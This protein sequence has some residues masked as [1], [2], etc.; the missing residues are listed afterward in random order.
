MNRF[1]HQELADMRQL[2]KATTNLGKFTIT[3]SPTNEYR[4]IQC[5]SAF[6]A[7]ER[8]WFTAQQ[9]ARYDERITYADD[10]VDERVL[11]T[12]DS[13]PNTRARAIAQQLEVFQ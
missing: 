10:N 9:H 12:I 3:D 8:T 5:L 11:Q 1:K 4:S 7:T 13:N 6:I 2:V